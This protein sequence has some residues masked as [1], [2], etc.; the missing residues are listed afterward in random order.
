M[1]GMSCSGTG[2]IMSI[3]PDMSAATRVAAL[4]TGMNT[5]SV[6]L[7]S[8][9]SHQVGLGTSTV[10]TPGSRDFSTKGPVPLACVLA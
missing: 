4:A 7:C 8:G 1:R 3:S 10:R 2:S 9:L 5:A 6:K